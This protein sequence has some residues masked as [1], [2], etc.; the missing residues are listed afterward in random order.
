[1]NISLYPMSLFIGGVAGAVAIWTLK[2]PVPSILVAI[3]GV[4]L[5][6]IILRVQ[7]KS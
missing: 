6:E 1:M 7:E 4:A 3:A 2:Q 5:T